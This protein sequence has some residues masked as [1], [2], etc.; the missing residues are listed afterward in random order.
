MHVCGVLW[1]TEL[2]VPPL[3]RAFETRDI[4]LA[5]LF[6]SLAGNP[7]KALQNVFSIDVQ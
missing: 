3:N 2:L 6:P 1:L 7:K 4:N 5:E